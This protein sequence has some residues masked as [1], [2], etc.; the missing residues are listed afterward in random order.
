MAIEDT[1][2]GVASAKGAGLAVVAV[3]RTGA[4]SAGLAAAGAVVVERLS[5]SDIGL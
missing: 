5:P 3:D 4:G 2:T 1:P